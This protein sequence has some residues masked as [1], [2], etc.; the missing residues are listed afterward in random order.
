MLRSKL[1]YNYEY[2]F[3]GIQLIKMLKYKYWL[4]SSRPYKFYKLM[5]SSTKLDKSSLKNGFRIVTMQNSLQKKKIKK[6]YRY[7]LLSM[8]N[9]LNLFPLGFF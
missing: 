2:V 9:T 4:D 6:N 7:Y 5:I 8:E 1:K 3:Q